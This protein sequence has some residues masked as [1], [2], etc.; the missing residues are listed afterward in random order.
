MPDSTETG[1]QVRIDSTNSLVAALDADTL[2]AGLKHALSETWTS[3]ISSLFAGK[4][5]WDDVANEIALELGESISNPVSDVLIQAWTDSGV[6]TRLW[7]PDSFDPEAVTRLALLEHSVAFEKSPSI[8]IMLNEKPL[9]EIVLDIALTLNVE[10]IILRIQDACLQQINPGTCTG[11]ARV[12]T[13]LAGREFVLV[14]KESEPVHL[15]MEIHL[16]PAVPI[17][18][19]SVTR[20][21]SAD[22]PQSPPS[23]ESAFS[24]LTRIEWTPLLDLGRPDVRIPGPS[25][26]T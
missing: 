20:P 19:R 17:F 2:N 1:R 7:D 16:N 3:R 6:F 25:A 23:T 4:Q 9:I 12:S 22:E 26:F 18:P 5:N 13:T 8:E 11:S 21:D 24:R 10:G 15:P 14:D